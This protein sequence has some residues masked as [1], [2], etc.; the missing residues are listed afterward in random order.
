VLWSAGRFFGSVVW[1][2]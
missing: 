2:T 1:R